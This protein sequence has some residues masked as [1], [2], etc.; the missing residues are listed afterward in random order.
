MKKMVVYLSLLFTAM[1]LSVQ[2]ERILEVSEE[3]SNQKDSVA[4]LDPA[5]DLFIILMPD[6]LYQKGVKK[7]GIFHGKEFALTQ[8][9]DTIFYQTYWL[10]SPVLSSDHV[11]FQHEESV[12]KKLVVSKALLEKIKPID[13]NKKL[14][15][16]KDVNAMLCFML[17]T[18]AYGSDLKR[19]RE[20]MPEGISNMER[21][22]LILSGKLKPYEKRVWLIDRRHITADSVLLLEVKPTWITD[23]FAPRKPIVK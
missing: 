13:M 2:A 16:L 8:S 19:V 22:K 17:D 14:A 18:L 21:M 10:V 6:G 9:L 23:G 5:K 1:S 20:V 7:E 12:A 4:M 15:Q 3:S 11:S